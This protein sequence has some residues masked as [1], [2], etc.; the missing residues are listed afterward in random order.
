[1]EDGLIA[2]TDE[3]AEPLK[4]LSRIEA[5][6]MLVR[7]LGLEDAQTSEVSYFADIASDNWGAKY[8][9]I[10]YDNGIAA[11]V[12]DN[13]FAPNEIIT[14][15]QFASLLLRSQNQPNDWQTAINTL[16]E[17]GILTQEEADKM[18]LF[19]RGDMAKIIYEAREQGLLLQDGN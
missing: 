5:T 3:G 9:N 1:M 6:A 4:P 14:S 2:G 13:Q 19:T 18:D 17:R 15:S 16:V 12:G 7:I 10:A 8:A 11:G